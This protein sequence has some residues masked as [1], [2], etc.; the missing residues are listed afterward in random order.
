MTQPKTH[1]PILRNGQSYR[2]L[3]S[4]ELISPSSGKGLT[5]ISQANAGLIRR[6]IRHIDDAWSALRS[7][8]CD[9]L[10]RISNKAGDL[11]MHE[12]LSLGLDG[13]QQSPEDFILQ[14][15]TTSCLPHT[16]VRRNMEKIRQVFTEMGSIIRGLTR[17]LDNSILDNGTGKQAGLDVCY[18]PTARSLGVVL[19]SNSP[20]VNSIWMPSIALK[21]PV[22]LKPGREEPWTPL[23]II[24]A[25]IA[26]G[27][28][29][30]AFGFYPT[31]HE[32]ASVI[33]QT[34]DR[35]LLFGDSTTTDPY[36]H[37]PEVQCH[38]PGW[39]KILIGE[40]KVDHW[41]EYIEV[42]VQSIAANG[43]RSCINASQVVTPRHGREIAE[44]IAGRLALFKPL[45]AD[46]RDAALAGFANPRFADYIDH[47]IGEGLGTPGAV[48]TSSSHRKAS[49]RRVEVD[50]IPYLHPT[51]IFCE[52]PDHPLAC[53]E[54]LFPYA[55]VIEVPQDKMTEVIGPTLVAT[56]ITTD[57]KWIDELLCCPEIDRLN[58]GT[59]PTSHV[60][61]DQPH[62]GNLFEFLYRRRAI[63][64]SI[65][66]ATA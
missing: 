33:L 63:N 14:L 62:E 61:W 65:Q 10:I 39:S 40:D 1:I 52:N 43:G 15:S 29:A 48:D 36:E 37:N 18:Y 53:R 56:A 22:I 24:H 57:K 19:P 45:P 4:I 66:A 34:C 50:G 46:D 17:G 20:G 2:S 27:C 64:Q 31:D 47:A 28:P 11:F 41:Q 6:D 32:G 30:E 16:L 12:A 5:L 49:P 38:G 13:E 25:F 9:E 8:S 7:F 60:E 58:I 42:M 21:V 26:A 59:I 51:I 3:D 55:S 23:R 44:T 35:S 54:F